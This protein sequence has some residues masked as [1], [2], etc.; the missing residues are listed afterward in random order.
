MTEKRKSI[1]AKTIE[2][3]TPGIVPYKTSLGNGLNVLTMPSGTKL[4]RLRYRIHN[5]EKTLSFGSFPIVSL[6]EVRLKAAQAREDVQNG[7]D[8]SAVKQQVKRHA[9]IC[10]QNT[11]KA[12]VRELV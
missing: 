9:V 1:T 10:A 7:I 3:L 8:P 4:F 6:H 11:F 12:I 2:N 5:K